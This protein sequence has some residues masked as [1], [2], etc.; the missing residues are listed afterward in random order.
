MK[1]ILLIV[2]GIILFV[3]IPV[4]VFFFGQQQ[5]LRKKAAPATTLSVEPNV[6]S[7]AVGETLICR[8]LIHAAENRVASAK[9]SLTFD[10][11]KFEAL[12]ITNGTLAPRILNQGTI[13]AGTATITVAAAST[14]KPI[15]GEG[16]IAVLRLKALNGSSTPVTI[17]FAPDTFVAGIGEKETNVLVSN[18]S[19]SVTITGEETAAI[20]SPSP[21]PSPTVA[22]S[23]SPTPTPTTKQLESL[24]SEPAST[25][26]LTLSVDTEATRGG[27]PLIKGTASQGSTV[28][29]VIHSTPSQTLVVIADTNGKWETTPKTALAA[30]TYTIVVTAVH[31]TT[32]SSETLSSSFVISSSSAIG[33]GSET[34]DTTG[35]ALPESG[36]ITPTLI[37]LLLGGLCITLGAVSFTK[38]I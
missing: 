19:G 32:G 15:T 12:S 38:N 7:I 31:P 22:G 30:G 8:V 5:D 29:I 14:T 26:A 21:T 3:S 17:Q 33:G 35:E 2:S 10:Q 18:Q 37:L 13:G 11:T 16:E 9:V 36:S 27:I 24:V 1:K 34:A 25:S 4:I 6:T 28:T 23:A 20:T